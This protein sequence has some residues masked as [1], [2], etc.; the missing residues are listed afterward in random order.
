[1]LRI[2]IVSGPNLNLLGRRETDVYGAKTLEQIEAGL[3]SLADELGAETV[4][5]QSN[6]EGAIIDR[7]HQ[8]LDDVDGI[9]INPGALTHYSFA[10]RDAIAAIAM[11]VVEVHMSNIHGRESF[12]QQSVTAA[13]CIGQIAGFGETSY[14]LGLRAVVDVIRA[15]ADER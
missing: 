15:G 5:Y 8:A 9:V 12:R 3:M 10:L 14:A 1:M 4:F 13:V 2:L 7:L 11:P 6:H